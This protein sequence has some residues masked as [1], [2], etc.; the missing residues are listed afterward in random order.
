M[1][2]GEQDHFFEIKIL[3]DFK[4]IYQDYYKKFNNPL[5]LT[6]EA[7]KNQLL[8]SD[9]KY[10]MNFSCE[11]YIYKPLIK[12]YSDVHS[13][14]RL[15]LD[16]LYFMESSNMGNIE[17]T[18]EGWEWLHNQNEPIVK[19]KNIKN[20]FIEPYNYFNTPRSIS[21]SDKI[22]KLLDEINNLPKNQIKKYQNLIALQLRTVLHLVL[23]DYW[24]VNKKQLQKNN[25]NSLHEII[26]HTI[27]C[28]LSEK[29]SGATKIIE[30]LNEIKNSKIKELI[31]D[32]VHCDFTLLTLEEVGYFQTRIK[33]LLSLVYGRL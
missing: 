17:F 23:I 24:A 10:G 33:H 26:K 6:L 1:Y 28:S 21:C 22:K 5:E 27:N 30:I 3:P 12:D 4:K 18:P 19:I 2:N 8:N 20:N 25:K 15:L 11:E 32:V 14:T 13:A 31:D 9:V 29:L 16:E 7:I